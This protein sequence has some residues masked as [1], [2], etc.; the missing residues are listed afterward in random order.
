MN[1]NFPLS[2]L[3]HSLRYKCMLD[4]QRNQSFCMTKLGWCFQQ[5]FIKLCVR[6][7][8]NNLEGKIGCGLTQK[9]LIMFFVFLLKEILIVQICE[10][11]FI[12]PS[13]TPLVWHSS[14][15]HYCYL[16]HTWIL[17]IVLFCSNLI[18]LLLSQDQMCLIMEQDPAEVY[19]QCVPQGCCIWTAWQLTFLG[20]LHHLSSFPSPQGVWWGRKGC[21]AELKLWEKVHQ[22]GAKQTRIVYWDILHLE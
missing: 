15:L 14:L 21:W 1:D 4:G 9:H 17:I 13:K 3:F 16:Y 12:H 7:F 20:S 8:R 10:N 5:V 19:R 18:S 22:S 11:K 6:G 2:N